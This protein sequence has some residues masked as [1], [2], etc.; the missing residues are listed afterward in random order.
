MLELGYFNLP[1]VK[2]SCRKSGD[3]VHAWMVGKARICRYLFERVED[4][5]MMYVTTHYVLY[6]LT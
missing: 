6:F 4:M 2:G 1:Y 5:K 3:G